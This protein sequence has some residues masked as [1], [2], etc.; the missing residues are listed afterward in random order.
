M[1]FL[2][3]ADWHL[4]MK[5]SFLPEEARVR[6]A[7]DRFEAVRKVARIAAEEGCAFVVVAGDVFDSNQLDRAVVARA[8]DALKE[9]TVPVIL[10]PGNHDPL[11]P[12]SLFRSQ[13]WQQLAP[14]KVVVPTAEGTVDLPGVRGV[15]VVALPL[16]TKRRLGDPLSAFYSLRPPPAGTAR[17]VVG[18]GAV[19]VLLGGREDPSLIGQRALREAIADEKAQY[20]ALGDRHSF[21]E[22]P[23]CQG[24]AF[25]S[26]T[27]VATGWGEARPGEVVVVAI[28]GRELEVGTRP[29]GRWA[30][31]SEER[32]LGAAADVEALGR[33]FEG[34]PNKRTTAV[35]LKLS[36]TL[37]LDD[38]ATLERLLDEQADLLA[39]L[40]YDR[41]NSR[42]V[43]APDEAD[44]E[45][46]SLSG[47][48]R[49]ALEELRE[50][51]IGVGG[52]AQTA[53]DA[54]NLLYRLAR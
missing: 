16:L 9:F 1:R 47:Y 29:V 52:E 51:A 6:F 54:L 46:L 50:R 2:H 39:Y 4:G 53:R 32:E 37:S 25:Y 3:S 45:A 48:A 42:L 26:G 7:E 44:L 30:F 34:I 40:D 14:E 13:E 15:E 43:V 41:S 33:W 10:L 49:A 21:T 5:A 28:D 38:Y 27:P 12:T 23:G 31:L 20:V 19:D 18:H 24:R 22:V 35:R 36:G 17:V 8:A 11:D